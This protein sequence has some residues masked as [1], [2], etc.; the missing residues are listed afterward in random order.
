VT[1]GCEVLGTKRHVRKDG[2]GSISE[3][4]RGGQ[5]SPLDTATADML[6]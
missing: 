4:A 1:V 6:D 3:A 5:C 2:S